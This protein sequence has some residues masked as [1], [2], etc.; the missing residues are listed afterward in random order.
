MSWSSVPPFAAKGKSA[1]SRPYPIHILLKASVHHQKR[2]V[3]VGTSHTCGGSAETDFI[4]RAG[5]IATLEPVDKEKMVPC[6]TDGARKNV[7]GLVPSARS[8]AHHSV[9]GPAAGQ[10]SPHGIHA[11]TTADPALR[12]VHQ[13][14]RRW[15]EADHVR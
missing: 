8:V 15:I 3:N 6:A 13:V 4:R 11:G 7:G 12:G 14:T 1:A 10:G 2:L 5:S 9:C